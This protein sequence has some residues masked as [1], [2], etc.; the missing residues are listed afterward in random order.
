MVGLW[1]AALCAAPGI[2]V[3]AGSAW[4]ADR[5][6]EEHVQAAAGREDR[7][8]IVA[9]SAADDDRMHRVALKYEAVIDLLDG[10]LTLDQVLTRFWDVTAGCPEA[11]ANLRHG[12]TA[13]TTDEECLVQ[14]VLAF[15]RVHA[16]RHPKRYGPVFARLESAA[17]SRSAE[18]HAH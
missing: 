12:R 11:L 10:R 3:L 18:S 7:E 17:Q 13:T 16:A 4:L 8:V 1:R 9:T 2:I 15:A 5:A 14:Q 6:R